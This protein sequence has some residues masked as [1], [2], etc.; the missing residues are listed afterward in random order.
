MQKLN[1]NTV[2]PH[3]NTTQKQKKT[4]SQ[5]TDQQTQK[6]RRFFKPGVSE[7]VPAMQAVHTDAPAKYPEKISKYIDSS[8]DSVR[9]S[10]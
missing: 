3:I 8:R 4:D 10:S 1:F 6:G 2:R 7:Y 5:K 9:E